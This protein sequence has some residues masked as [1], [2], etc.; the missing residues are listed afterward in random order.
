[1]LKYTLALIFLF[2]SFVFSQERCDGGSRCGPEAPCCSQFGY[3]GTTWEYCAAGCNLSLSF[4]PSSCFNSPLPHT[5]AYIPPYTPA[6]NPNLPEVRRCSKDSAC[7]YDAP[8]CSQFGYCGSG[9]DYCHSGCS[10]HGSYSPLSCGNH[11][12]PPTAYPEIPVQPH[13]P[14]MNEPIY[15][16]LD[17]YPVTD[18]NNN[19]NNNDNWSNPNQNHDWSMQTCRPWKLEDNTNVSE[20]LE[21]ETPQENTLFSGDMETN[22]RNGF[23][24]GGPVSWDMRSLSLQMVRGRELSSTGV[25]AGVGG[26]ARTKRTFRYGKFTARIKSARVGGVVSAFNLISKDGDEVDFEFVGH[27]EDSVQTNYYYKGILDYSKGQFSQ[28]PSNTHYNYHTYAVHWS[29]DALLYFIDGQLIRKVTRDS[30]YNPSTQ[31]FNFPSSP[32]QVQFMLWDGG[33][34]SPGTRDWAGGYIN[35]N[36]A[37]II[38]N[39]GFVDMNVESFTYECY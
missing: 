20:S 30:T 26:W 6:H 14:P 29:R 5:P 36:D 3:C 21:T 34:G 16:P 35:W 4:N 31:S 17:T 11:P 33:A 25:V 19:N 8:C 18:S 13:Y 10:V 38:S 12:M 15:P 22:Y 28:C 37:E 39:G 9:P 1:M 7:P 2:I 27:K 32:V 23:I 24:Y